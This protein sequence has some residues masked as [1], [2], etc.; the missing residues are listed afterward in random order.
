MHAR[1]PCISR[2]R[3]LHACAMWASARVKPVQDGF[4]IPTSLYCVHIHLG[5]SVQL[6]PSPPSRL[7]LTDSQKG[8]S[9]PFASRRLS[10]PIQM[11][12]ASDDGAA[13]PRLLGEGR[14]AAPRRPA[15][16]TAVRVGSV[17]RE[18][19]EVRTRGATDPVACA[20]ILLVCLCAA[21]NV[22]PRHRAPP[23]CRA[24]RSI[25]LLCVFA[26]CLPT[27]VGSCVWLRLFAAAN[28]GQCFEECVCAN[29]CDYTQIGQRL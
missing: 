18:R 27:H 5:L 7:Q 6:S 1:S 8:C 14:V 29:A 11:T 15:Q 17:G 25:C 22:L 10:F 23:P 19:R 24:C 13:A 16:R 4:A 21:L 28:L 26:V 2:R 20:T 3:V 9:T 12:G